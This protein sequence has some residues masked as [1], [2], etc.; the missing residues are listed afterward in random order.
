[1]HKPQNLNAKTLKP[2]RKAAL[3]KWN[4]LREM[5]QLEALPC[6]VATANAGLCGLGFRV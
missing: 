1:M 2:Y 5:R 6:A 4:R 3:S